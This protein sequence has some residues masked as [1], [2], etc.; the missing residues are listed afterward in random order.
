MVPITPGEDRGVGE[1][2]KLK[3]PPGLVAFFVAEAAAPA[4]RACAGHLD[5]FGTV[6]F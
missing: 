4:Q 3:G 6:P 2:R 5:Y 1:T